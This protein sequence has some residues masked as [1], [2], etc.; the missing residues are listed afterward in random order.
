MLSFIITL[1][2][3]M[4]TV[5]L[6]MSL[7]LLALLLVRVPFVPTPRNRV[8]KIIQELDVTTGMKFYD[9]GCGDGR[10]LFAAI[11]AGANATGYEVSA[12]ALTRA[13]INKWILRSSARIYLKNFYT[14]NLADADAVFCFLLDTVMPRVEEKLIAEL[15]PGTVV[16]SYG[17]QMPSWQPER[18]VVFDPE[19]KKA[20][21][22]Y[23]YRR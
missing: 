16:G 21:K 17:F 11:Q 3:I 19:N 23:I 7:S 12:S 6:L 22:L 5:A 10:F 14:Q 2:V 20:S 1:T 18:V 4:T 15:K 9:I 8:Q 13:Y